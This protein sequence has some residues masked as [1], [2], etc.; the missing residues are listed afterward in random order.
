MLSRRKNSSAFIEEKNMIAIEEE[1]D[2]PHRQTSCPTSRPIISHHEQKGETHQDTLST[3][4]LW[5][6]PFS[7]LYQSYKPN[8]MLQH[9][10]SG[11]RQQQQTL[12]RQSP[13]DLRC[14]NSFTTFPRRKIRPP[15][16][17]FL[18][19]ERFIL[20]EK[21]P[22]LEEPQR[23][24]F[25]PPLSSYVSS[26]SL[27]LPPR[28]NTSPDDLVIEDASWS[29]LMSQHQPV[30]NDSLIEEIVQDLWKEPI[31]DDFVGEQSIRE[32][33]YFEGSL[34]HAKG[35]P[36]QQLYTESVFWSGHGESAFWSGHGRQYCSSEQELWEP[37]N[38][39]EISMTW[40]PKD[41]MIHALLY[42]SE[43][44]LWQISR[45]CKLFKRAYFRQ[46]GKPKNRSN[47]ILFLASMGYRFP[48][49][50]KL[51]IWK[52]HF[53]TCNM[54]VNEYFF[55]S[56]REVEL[57]NCLLPN[58]CIH[59]KVEMLKVSHHFHA[60]MLSFYPNIRALTITGI[61]NIELGSVAPLLPRTLERLTLDV[62]VVKAGD[63]EVLGK[64]TELWLLSLCI[65][66]NQDLRRDEQVMIE[67]PESLVKLRFISIRGIESTP[68]IPQLKALEYLILIKIKELVITELP[69]LP[70]L[71][72]LELNRCGMDFWDIHLFESKY[73]VLQVL[74]LYPYNKHMSLNLDLFPT[75][76]SLKELTLAEVDIV[77]G[78]SQ[79][80]F[81]R[82]K[83]PRLAALT[84]ANVVLPMPHLVNSLKK[85]GDINTIS[86]KSCTFCNP[87]KLSE[88]VGVEHLV[89]K[90]CE[91]LWLGA[92]ASN[93]KVNSKLQSIIITK[94][95]INETGLWNLNKFP[96]LVEL[97]LSEN[98]LRTE[99]IPHLHHLKQLA[100]VS[101]NLSRWDVGRLLTNF[102][103]LIALDLR[104]NK[105][106][107]KAAKKHDSKSI[108]ILNRRFS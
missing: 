64:L 13:E 43:P 55:P 108:K 107:G 101:C 16:Q 49:L 7:P 26:S 97:D 89:F 42:L 72:T 102:P 98:S 20:C 51:K 104:G 21:L 22:K 91:K 92:L 63:C 15:T 12:W 85:T 25:P 75:L 83:T 94:C 39:E 67:I 34:R 81:Y 106:L 76:E 71:K 19:S 37:E 40:L 59:P 105:D 24:L 23:T 48:K 99:N 95:K 5:E 44:T 6:T 1:Y 103:A 53:P 82:S 68:V 61:S 60:D 79:N 78:E 47:R 73:P 4:E 69:S 57:A 36:L 87:F 45:T 52:L 41:V 10:Q 56:L 96:N 62:A 50:K 70:S 33:E 100:M 90:N 35:K 46:G 8:F 28:D 77:L 86:F 3:E 30:T 17:R 84:L 14:Q 66:Q 74:L 88:F 2:Y 31:Y 93:P 65:G 32:Y 29:S 58:F 38:P 11:L 27:P 54:L 18:T 80:V 9:K